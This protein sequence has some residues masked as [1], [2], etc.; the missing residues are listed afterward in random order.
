M[1][2]LNYLV[3]GMIGLASLGIFGSCNKKEKEAKTFTGIVQKE[4]Y[5]DEMPYL[6]YKVGN[7]KDT[8]L[9]GVDKK[10][11][12]FYGEIKYTFF[13][14]GDS[15]KVDYVDILENQF[16]VSG[17]WDFNAPCNGGEIREMKMTKLNE[18][19]ILVGYQILK[20]KDASE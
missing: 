7:N 20:R 18:L 6:V 19:S 5:S 9:V 13:H 1:K 3:S 10:A 15:V 16:F 8:I 12:N 11:V 17:N 2:T 4:I 14:E